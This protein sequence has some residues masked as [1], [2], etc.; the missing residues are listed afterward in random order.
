M[1]QVLGDPE[2]RK[3]HDARL[4][5]ASFQCK[6]MLYDSVSIE[7]MELDAELYVYQCR[8]GG[9]YI[10]EACKLAAHDMLL[11][12]SACSLY[13]KVSNRDGSAHESFDAERGHQ[14]LQEPLHRGVQNDARNS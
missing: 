2:L 11:A 6:A 9:E 5:A 14:S 12:C 13:L 3:E 10:V 4:D 7:D 1:M 8:C